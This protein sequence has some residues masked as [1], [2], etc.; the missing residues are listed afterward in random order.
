MI[1]TIKI[2]GMSAVMLASAGAFAVYGTANAATA[3]NE[4]CNANPTLE[5]FSA[6]YV[7]GSATQAHVAYTGEVPLCVG[8][9]KTFALNAYVTEGSTWETSGKQ[10]PVDHDTV[11]LSASQTE[12]DLSVELPGDD[13]FFQTDLFGNGK[14]YDGVDGQLPHYPDTETPEDY[15]DSRTGGTD[16]CEGGNGGGTP[17]PTPEVLGVT[18]LPKTGGNLGGI[19]LGA[20]LVGASVAYLRARRAR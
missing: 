15:I 20:G 1:K 4:A 3:L 2:A 19:A 17:T 18:E 11:T 16:M 9:T 12:G 14:K 10:V 13:C 7:N 8:V 6:A 5:Q